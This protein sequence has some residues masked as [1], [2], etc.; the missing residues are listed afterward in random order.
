MIDLAIRLGILAVASC[1]PVNSVGPPPATAS[2]STTVVETFVDPMPSPIPST[3]VSVTEGQVLEP[4]TSS[5]W[6]TLV[7][8]RLPTDTMEDSPDFDC[9]FH[10]D[11]VCG[12]GHDPVFPHLV[13]VYGV[14]TDSLERAHALS[15]VIGSALGIGSDS[16]VYFA[17]ED[18]NRLIDAGAAAR[19]VADEYG[20]DPYDVCD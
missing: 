1:A 7:P 13:T 6:T 17:P 14:P 18:M 4:I 8:D 5:T 3:P 19:A 12:V 2:T 9:R 11:R 20:C 10:G 15:L 16:G